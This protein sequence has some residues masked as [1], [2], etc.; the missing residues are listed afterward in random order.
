MSRTL[1]A[2]TLATFG[3][4]GAFL[5][6]LPGLLAQNANSQAGQDAQDAWEAM[7]SDRYV[8]WHPWGWKVWM[9]NPLQKPGT[10][11]FELR[12]LDPSRPDVTDPK[13]I[14]GGVLEAGGE[15]Y[16]F[17]PAGE[18]FA[19]EVPDARIAAGVGEVRV[20]D[21]TGQDTWRVSFQ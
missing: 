14:G 11:R 12:Y 1:L 10:T 7:P 3:V 17:E 18:I 5:S 6:G 2:F 9:E 15:V 21:A 19:V 16:T 8:A 13:P 20:F 4:L